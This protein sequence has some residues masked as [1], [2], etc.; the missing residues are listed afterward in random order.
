VSGESIWDI[1]KKIGFVSPELHLYFD[2][3]ATCFEVIAS[4]LFDTVGLF[5]HLSQKQ[6]E[7]VLL[8]LKLFQLE[9]LQSKRLSQISVSEQRRTLLARAL[10]KTPP[11]L[12]LDE[13]C[14]GLDDEQ[15]SHFKNLINQ[16][17][18]AFDATLVY[19]SHYQNQIPECV[20]HFLRLENGSVV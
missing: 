15:T 14:Q 18:K 2:F 11:L 3:S 8:W 9:N 6:N 10:I 5:R 4:G 12:I 7:N 13:P 19:V 20:N 1:K 16:V 17:C